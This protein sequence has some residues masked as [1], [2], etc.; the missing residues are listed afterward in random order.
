MRLN[1]VKDIGSQ[2]RERR[3]IYKNAKTI[4]PIKAVYDEGIFLGTDGA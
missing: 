2:R 3:K 1:T 4:T